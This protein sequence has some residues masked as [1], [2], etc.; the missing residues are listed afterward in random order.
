MKQKMEEGKSA[1]SKRDREAKDTDDLFNEA[2]YINKDGWDGFN[3]VAIRKAMI[4]ACRLVDFKMTLAKLSIFV[5]QDG[6]QALR[7]RCRVYHE[8]PVWWWRVFGSRQPA[9]QDSL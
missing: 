2:R 1:S 6:W 4:S 7:C 3:A 9:H 5:M 8:R